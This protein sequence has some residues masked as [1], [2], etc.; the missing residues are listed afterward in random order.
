MKIIGHEKQW[1]FLKKSAELGKISHAYLFCGQEKLG[2]KTVALEWISLITG[3]PPKKQHPDL[4]LIEPKNKTIQISQIRDLIWKLSLKPYS[5]SIKATIIDQAHLMGAEAQSAL[6]KTLE[7]PKGDALLI[8]ISE[9][10][11]ML[12]PT[13]RSRCEILKFYPVKKLKIKNYLKQKGIPEGE[14]GAIASISRGRP[15]EAIDFILRPQKL[16]N[17]KKVIKELIEISN[18]SLSLRFQYAKDLSQSRNLKEILDIWL[19]FFRDALLSKTRGQ[20][21]VSQELERYSCQKLRKILEFVQR[22]NFLLSATNINQK[23]ALEIL[24]LEL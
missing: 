4:I 11:A 12:F 9:K 20:V 23:L 13:I 7:E 14:A 10:P 18:S 24:V 1:R 17:R 2:K 5:A 3:W 8:L 21:S 22:I 19:S 15:G 6:L 16:E